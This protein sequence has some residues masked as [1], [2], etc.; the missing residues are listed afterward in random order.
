MLYPDMKT[1]AEVRQMAVDSGYRVIDSL[2]LPDSSFS[3]AASF[4]ER[5]Q[6]QVYPPGFFAR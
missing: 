2:N 3:S 5:T 4:Y 1:I 6:W